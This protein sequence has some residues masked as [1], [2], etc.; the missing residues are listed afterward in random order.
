MS[1]RTIVRLLIKRLSGALTQDEYA[2]EL[3]LEGM[4]SEEAA[5]CA[6]FRT[7]A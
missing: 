3:E 2:W 4:S 6:G 1:E 7:N 5:K